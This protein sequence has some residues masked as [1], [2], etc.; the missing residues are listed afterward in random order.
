[1][2]KVLCL[3]L[4]FCCITFTACSTVN[5]RPTASVMVG[6]DI[7]NSAEALFYG[8]FMGKTC[9]N[10]IRTLQELGP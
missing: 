7:K 3:S 5:V 1:M 6:T 10:P 9:V 4:I 2:T 8:E